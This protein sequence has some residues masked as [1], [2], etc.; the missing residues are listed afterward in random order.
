[1][2]ATIVI[3]VLFMG[4]KNVSLTDR[5][6]LRIVRN[7]YAIVTEKMG[8]NNEEQ[9][10]IKKLPKCNKTVSTKLKFQKFNVD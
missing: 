10:L 4:N 9:K 7:I 3:I 5:V 2:E 6:R 1:M 8:R